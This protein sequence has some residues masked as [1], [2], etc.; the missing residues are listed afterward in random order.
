M[1][2]KYATLIFDRPRNMTKMTSIALALS[3]QAPR[4]NYVENWSEIR[5]RVVTYALEP[6]IVAPNP[7]FNY[8]Q[9]L[10]SNY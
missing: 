1:L 3:T 2:A 8:Y 7:S 10:V 9:V 4:I 5:I 6:S